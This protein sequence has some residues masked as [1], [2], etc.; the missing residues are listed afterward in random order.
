MQCRRS[1]SITNNFTRRRLWCSGPAPLV[2]LTQAGYVWVVKTA[3]PNSK[4]HMVLLHGR[5][6]AEGSHTRTPD[7]FGWTCPLVSTEKKKKKTWAEKIRIEFPEPLKFKDF[8]ITFPTCSPFVNIYLQNLLYNM[9]TTEA[10]WFS[11]PSWQR[12]KKRQMVAILWQFVPAERHVLLLRW[13]MTKKS[14][15]Q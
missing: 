9:C 8:N 13:K 11:L 1:V 7:R 15:I 2:C 10:F 12:C 5:P 14:S 6:R 4:R 3:H